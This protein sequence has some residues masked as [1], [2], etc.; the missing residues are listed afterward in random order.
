M[1]SVEETEQEESESRPKT[2]IDQS[3][4]SDFA[5]DEYYHSEAH[6]SENNAKIGIIFKDTKMVKP[7]Q[8]DG[9]VPDDAV[10]VCLIG[11]EKH[12]EIRD[13]TEIQKAV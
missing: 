1:K 10:Q 13:Y 9:S 5:R 11:M 7:P 3:Y 2:R 12:L 8:Y 6:N 4:H